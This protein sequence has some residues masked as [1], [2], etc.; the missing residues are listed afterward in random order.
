MT[1]RSGL[2]SVSMESPPNKRVYPVSFFVVQSGK[3]HNFTFLFDDPCA[4]EIELV[5]ND[6]YFRDHYTG[7]GGGDY[8]ICLLKKLTTN[9]T[10]SLKK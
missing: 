5:V 9:T 3:G 10:P 4:R 1:R 7:G 6:T 2:S 8:S